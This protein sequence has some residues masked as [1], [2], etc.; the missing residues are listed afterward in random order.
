MISLT[1]IGLALT[2][3]LGQAISS[4]FPE[5]SL[6]IG[7]IGAALYW[8]IASMS[9]GEHPFRL[10]RSDSRFAVVTWCLCVLIFLHAILSN[11]ITDGVDFKRLLGSTLILVVLLTG[12]NCAVTTILRVTPA[13]LI[14]TTSVLFWVLTLMGLWG[15]AG[16]PGLGSGF[17]GKS[18]GVFEEPSHFG[19]AYLPVLLFR[20]SVAR[21]PT[22]L[23]LL[24]SA[25]VVAGLLQSLTMV[26]GIAITA[27]L[28]LRSSWLLLFIAPVGAVAAALDLTYYSDR[29]TL[30]S[31]SS[32]LSTLVFLQ[33]WEN[34]V[35]NFIETH[36]LGVGFQQ[37]GIAGSTGEITAKLSRMLQGSTINLMDGSTAGS[38]LIGEFGV[39]GLALIV[40][41]LVAAARSIRVIR[42]A[43]ALRPSARDV[44]RLFFCS[45][46]TTYIFEIF[47]RGVGYFDGGAFL[48]VV[49]LIGRSRLREANTPAKAY[50]DP[51]LVTG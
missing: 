8:I 33:G 46:V 49:A 44:H 16:L 32:N 6:S 39:I 45:L 41:F 31:D 43:Q 38:K 36:G 47:I 35:T 29:L 37:F 26:A 1:A 23:L 28:L 15:A 22:Q 21:K 14:R 10:D 20:M 9:V 24:V 13:V 3:M 42:A 50:S 51:A 18:V 7:L 30:S 17:F 4:V 19:L 5:T 40:A 12:A 48:A 27:S 11:L 2:L 34:A 25:L